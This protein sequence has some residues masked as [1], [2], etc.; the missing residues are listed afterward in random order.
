MFGCE[1]ESVHS[2]EEGWTPV[3]VR[4]NLFLMSIAFLVESRNE[5]V[6]NLLKNI[7]LIFNYLTDNLAWSSQ[8]CID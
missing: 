4:D 8:E 1:D 7:F 2:S 6:F 3:Y 5:A